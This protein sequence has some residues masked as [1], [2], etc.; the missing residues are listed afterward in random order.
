MGKLPGRADL[1]PVEA[2]RAALKKGKE[3]KGTNPLAKMSD[4]SIAVDYRF[5]QIAGYLP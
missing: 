5:L 1:P 2:M 4:D 3:Y